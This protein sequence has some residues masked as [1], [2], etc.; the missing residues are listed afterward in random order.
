MESES[1]NEPKS[2]AGRLTNLL[3]N[4]DWLSRTGG[5]HQS[6]ENIE[7]T[8]RTVLRHQRSHAWV[9]GHHMF[10]DP[11]DTVIA[12]ILSDTGCFEP[13]ETELMRSLVRPGDTV[14]D[15]GANIGY[16]TLHFA[17]GVGPT[18]RV[19]AFEP[20]PGNFA[21]LKSNIRQNGY[22]NVTMMQKAVGAE[23]GVI[24]LFRNPE[25]RGDHRT[26][27]SDPNRESI[28]V[29]VVALD[30]YFA[31][32]EGRI[33]FLKFDI[34]GFEGAA[35]RGM[36]QLLAQHRPLRMVMEFW[37]RGLHM[38]GYRPEELLRELLDLGFAIQEIDD[39]SEQLVPLDIPGMLARLPI[40]K[41][42][43]MLFTNI[44]CERQAN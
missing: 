36:S 16:Y 13:Y 34:Q 32:I 21:L 27:A 1:R 33:D 4:A 22:T 17:C 44:Y 14:I 40:E 38:A 7:T 43:D 23:S 41:D 28:E 26:Y 29:G 8:L 35:L 12:P 42:T 31:N 11:D 3:H 18:G 15:V 30:D 25:N 5:L 19:F 6:I 9:Y 10:L 37:P 24:Q 39:R 2:L 20:D